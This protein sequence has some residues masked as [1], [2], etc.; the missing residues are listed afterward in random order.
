MLRRLNRKGRK[1]RQ[2]LNIYSFARFAFSAVNYDVLRSVSY[3]F[4]CKVFML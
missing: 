1:E 4:R 2:V 3:Q